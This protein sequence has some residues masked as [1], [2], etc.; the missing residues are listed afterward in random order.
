MEGAAA[1]P[2][3]FGSLPCRRRRMSKSRL[4]EAESTI[5]RP[6]RSEAP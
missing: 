2:M 5:S 1:M 6:E 4:P 3:P